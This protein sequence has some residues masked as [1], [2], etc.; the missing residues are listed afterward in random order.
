MNDYA[1]RHQVT[2][3][4]YCVGAPTLYCVGAP[5]VAVLFE[6]DCDFACVVQSDRKK[7]RVG[8]CLASRKVKVRNSSTLLPTIAPHSTN[9][10]SSDYPKVIGSS[11]QQIKKPIIAPKLAGSVSTSI[12]QRLMRAELNDD[13]LTDAEATFLALRIHADT[14]SLCFESTTPSDA[15]ALAWLMEF[16]ASQAAISAQ[17]RAASSSAVQSSLQPANY[18]IAANLSSVAIQLP[19][20]ST[21]AAIDSTF[22]TVAAS[23]STF[24]ADDSTFAVQSLT[25]FTVAAINSTTAAHLPSVS[26]QLPNNTTVAV[27]DSSF[28]A[29]DSTLAIQSAADTTFAA[30]DST[31]AVQSP[32]NSSVAANA[33]M[34]I[35]WY[36]Y[37]SET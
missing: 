3:A 37:N 9:Q 35:L 23:D 11:K 33:L 31:F 18:T 26:V 30:D 24:A 6:C 15:Q 21:V 34:Q 7:K 2:A 28:A 13:R 19:I 22:F 1:S 16:G 10:L 20:N 4:L 25:N 27:H 17:A 29:D 32:T 8:A 14:G 12:V 5:T 36:R